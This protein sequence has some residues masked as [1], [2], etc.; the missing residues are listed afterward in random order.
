MLQ[1]NPERLARFTAGLEAAGLKL[2]GQRTAVC[3]AL[4][5]APGHPTVQE[6]YERAR[7]RAGSIS[8]ATV[9]NTMTVLK[10]LGLV[11]ELGPAEGGTYFELDPTPHANLL[12]V[13]C[14]Q[15]HDVHLPALAHIDEQ[16]RAESGFQILDSRILFTG[17]CSSCQGMGN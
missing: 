8:L 5:E 13:R 3:A 1:V 10:D 6:I 11:V 9:Y 14:K 17:V 15:V 4:A 16:V 7:E 12:C 2:T